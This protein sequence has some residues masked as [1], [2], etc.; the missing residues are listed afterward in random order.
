M[1]RALGSFSPGNG[2][3]SWSMKLKYSPVVLSGSLSMSLSNLICNDK[4]NH[5]SPSLWQEFTKC[6]NARLSV[7]IY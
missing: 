1:S 4:K 3:D 6:I 7:L 5:P 2:F